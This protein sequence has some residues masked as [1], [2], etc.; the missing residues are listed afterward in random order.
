VKAAFADLLRP[1]PRTPASDEVSQEP[2]AA[3]ASDPE[4]PGDASGASRRS[5][6]RARVPG[7]SAFAKATADVAEA[8]AEARR[9][10]KPLG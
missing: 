7:S 2:A 6:K 3:A 10:A 9:G 4:R 5:G 8:F 1:P